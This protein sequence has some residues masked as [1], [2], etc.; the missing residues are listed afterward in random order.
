ML[1]RGEVPLRRFYLRRKG[2][3]LELYEH[4]LSAAPSQALAVA[5]GSAEQDELDSEDGPGY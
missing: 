5:G 3:N 4:L 1:T 2:F